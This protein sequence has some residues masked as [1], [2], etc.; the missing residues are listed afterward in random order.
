SFRLCP[1][2]RFAGCLVA[3]IFIT[4]SRRGI[5]NDRPALG[6]TPLS[7]RRQG[8]LSLDRD[9]QM[10]RLYYHPLSSNSRRVLLTAYHLG[11]NLE[12]VVVDLSRGEHK[13]PDICV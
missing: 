4:R 6:H 8:F 12:L 11:L 5:L 1:A 2:N 10:M 3:L 13:T 7:I 9:G